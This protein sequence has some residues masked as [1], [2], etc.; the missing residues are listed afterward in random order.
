MQEEVPRAIRLSD[1]KTGFY[2]DGIDAI[3]ASTDAWD[4]GMYFMEPGME[5]II[6]SLEEKDDGDAE[7]WYG[8]SYEFYFI[9]MGEFTVWYGKDADQLKKKNGPKLAL[10]AGDLASYPPG[11]KYLVQNTGKIPG[12]FFWG[13]S[14]VPPGVRPRENEPLKTLE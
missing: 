9:L 13:K 11:W 3:M 2:K 7:E 8:G 4:L 14:A 10:G 12:S 5:T 6:F 1:V